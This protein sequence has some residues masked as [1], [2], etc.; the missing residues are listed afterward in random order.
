MA[1]Y[2]YQQVI[3]SKDFFE[4]YFLDY[5]P[6]D[7]KRIDPPYISFNKL[8]CVK[9]I[10]E[11]REQFGEYIYYGY[12]FTHKIRSDGLMVLKFATKRDV[13]IAAIRAAIKLDHSLEWYAVEENCIYVPRFYWNHGVQEEIYLLDDDDFGRWVEARYEFEEALADSDHIVWYYLLENKNNWLD[14]ATLLDL[15]RYYE[16]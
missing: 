11:Y 15:P 7:E 4:T 2:V 9:N 10:G 1:N 3:C 5:Y 14:R 8:V 6:I 16:E 13:P 12:G